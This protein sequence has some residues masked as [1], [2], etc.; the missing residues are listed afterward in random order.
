M[1]GTGILFQTANIEDSLDRYLREINEIPL[2]Q[3]SEE[4][5]LAKRIRAGDQDALEMLTKSN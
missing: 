4:I 3:A 5:D 2:L 1:A